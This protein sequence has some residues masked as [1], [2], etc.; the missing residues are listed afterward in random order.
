MV[1]DSQQVTKKWSVRRLCFLGLAFVV[2]AVVL[3]SNL[4]TNQSHYKNLSLN[5]LQG[6]A[7]AANDFHF[8]HG[9]YPAAY[10][11]DANGKPL[12]SWRVFLLPY[13]GESH[14]YNEFHLDEPWDSAHNKKLI[15]KMPAI[16]IHALFNLEPGKTVYLAPVGSSSLIAS[17]PRID[18][19]KVFRD[20]PI[21]LYGN[22]DIPDNDSETLLFVEANTKH[23]VEWTRPVDYEWQSSGIVTHGLEG[24]WSQNEWLGVS[25]SGGA[26]AYVNVD[27]F[28]FNSDR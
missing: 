19:D 25:A 15:E 23:A 9:S 3:L 26:K 10:A 16:Y 6:L 7:L 27:D 21:F 8:N 1:S 11:S 22:A 12:L 24:N 2:I 5:A 18:E 13:I 4:P 14:L 20:S 17:S 28:T